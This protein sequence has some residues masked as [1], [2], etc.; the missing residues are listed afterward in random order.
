MDIL[1][2]IQLP[3]HVYFYY[4][5]PSFF[6]L[7]A[8]LQ[9]ELPLATSVFYINKNNKVI[10]FSTMVLMLVLNQNLFK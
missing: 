8:N 5:Y 10:F 6:C 9:I 2:I 4:K 3:L 7:V 1:Q